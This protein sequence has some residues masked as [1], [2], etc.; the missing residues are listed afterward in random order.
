MSRCVILSLLCTCVLGASAFAQT[1]TPH[2]LTDAEVNAAINRVRNLPAHQLDRKLPRTTLAEWLQT[3]AGPNAKANWVYRSDPTA[4][5][6]GWQGLPDAAEADIA[7]RNE[8]SI[9]VQVAVS[10]C[11]RSIIGCRRHI[12]SVF[13]VDVITGKDATTSKFESAELDR[14]SDLPHFLRGLRATSGEA[15]R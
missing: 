15:E 13:R 8:R 5:T 1:G 9:V 2:E 4:G 14:L 6:P 3:Q 11:D 7:L 12:P 10:R